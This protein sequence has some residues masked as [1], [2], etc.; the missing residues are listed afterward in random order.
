MCFPLLRRVYCSNFAPMRWKAK[1][2]GP[3]LS[4]HVSG[5]R[6]NAA[7]SAEIKPMAILVGYRALRKLIK[8][9]LSCEL[10]PTL[11]RTS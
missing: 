7:A 5:R 11:K 10:K 1:F 6:R 9:C 3:M 8:S 2:T 4:E